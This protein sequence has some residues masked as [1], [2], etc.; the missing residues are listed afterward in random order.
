[1]AGRPGVGRSRARGGIDELPSGAI[2][3]RVYAGTDPLTGR[4]LDLT[5]V[6]PAG[7]AAWDEAE[8]TRARFLQ[9]IA[10]R[11][12]PRTNATVSEL[13]TRYLDQLGG[14]P[15]TRKLYRGHVRNHIG[16]CLGHLKVGRLD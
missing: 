11:R 6:V 16:P 3:V 10:E 7:P 1:M 14:A 4:R 13:L 8:A 9:E 2:R 12:N 15:G 5:E